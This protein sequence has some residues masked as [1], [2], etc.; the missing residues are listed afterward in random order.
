MERIA[1]HLEI[2]DGKREAYREKHEDVPEALEE[3]YLTS[4]AGLETYSV[5]EK[6]GHVFGYMELEDREKIR[7][8]MESS[9]AQSDWNEVMDP[10]LEDGD[11]D[12]WMDEVYRMK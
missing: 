5:F 11:G 8:V 6:D 7:R 1:F 12:M 3:A 10:I 9:K 2:A 4:G